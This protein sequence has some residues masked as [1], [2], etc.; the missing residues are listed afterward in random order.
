M[1][2]HVS[3]IFLRADRVRV[4]PGATI[5]L[6]VPEVSRKSKVALLE[7]GLS[8]M[9]LAGAP[10]PIG[11]QV[12][13]T[14][15]LEDRYIE[16]ELPGVVTGHGEH[17]FCVTFAHLSAR[18]TYGLTLSIE[19]ARQAARIASLVPG[20]VARATPVIGRAEPAPVSVP[21]PQRVARG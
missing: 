11:T 15:V 2:R 12:G 13:A 5:A 14:F 6:R 9:M 7:L 8:D 3:G 21:V 20:R 16:F 19:L 10:P 1:T 4:A 17:D 18:Q